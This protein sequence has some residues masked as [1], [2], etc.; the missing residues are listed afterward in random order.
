MSNWSGCEDGVHIADPGKA[1][2]CLANSCKHMN[3]C[4]YH[5]HNGFEPQI[6]KTALGATE[7]YSWE[8][9]KSK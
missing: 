5:G 9:E 3:E 4:M 7:C 8:F 2:N 1:A 6:S